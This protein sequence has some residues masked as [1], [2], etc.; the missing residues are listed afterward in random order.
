MNTLYSRISVLF[1]VFFGLTS[2]AQETKP[3]TLE[4]CVA[5]ATEHNVS[6]KQASLEGEQAKINKKGRLGA[7]LPNLNANT[8]YSWSRG[9][10]QNVTTGLLE[11]ATNGN[12]SVGVNLGVT[13][14]NGFK[15]M[16]QLR[17]ANL[18]LLASKY[19]YEKIVEDISVNIATAYLQVLFAKENLN[20]AQAQ[21]TIS[22]EEIKRTED[23]V[24]AGVRPRGDLL[25][26]EATISTNEQRVVS[27]E[28]SVTM[29]LLSLGQLLQLED[30]DNFDVAPFNYEI[31]PSEIATKDWKT[32]YKAAQ[33]NRPSLQIAENN[34][35]S[36][37]L[38]IKIAKGSRYPTLSGFYNWNSRYTDRNKVTGYVL[39]TANPTRTIGAVS[40][41]GDVVVAPNFKPVLGAA[42]KLFDQYKNNKGSAFGL[43]LR[44]PIFNGFSTENSIKSAKIGLKRA[45]FTKTQEEF[46]LARTIKT[47]YTDFQGAIKSYEAATKSYEAQKQAVNYAKER[48]KLG[49]LNAFD[50]NQVKTRLTTAEV[51]ML[52]AKYTYLF[53]QKILEYYYGLPLT[54]N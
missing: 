40:T 3:W 1:L 41:T 21:L 31:K 26:I 51:N 13:L 12:N 16:N 32:I 42:D 4:A 24:T 29:A 39:D 47:A 54:L 52:Q 28:N 27:A 15:N 2:I 18:A 19:R 7:M 6:I 20:A 45:E 17:K 10:S 48:Y 46:N 44:I 36:A 23:L 50:Y 33:A 9:L 22:K 11:Q 49:L 38:D 8:N 35:A 30:L 5:Y 14:F 37:K 43:S 25:D 53:K 34:I